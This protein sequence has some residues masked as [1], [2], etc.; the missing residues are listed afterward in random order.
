MSTGTPGNR[1]VKR[2]VAPH[3]G[4]VALRQ[5]N[6]TQKKGPINF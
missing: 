4:S 3:I 1:V 6:L 2:R 5:V